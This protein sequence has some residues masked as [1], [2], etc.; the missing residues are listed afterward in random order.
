MSNIVWRARSRRAP[1]AGYSVIELMMT[2]GIFAVL[3]SMAVL[4]IGQ[5]QPSIKGDGALRV[6]LAQ[7]NAALEMAITNR[8]L[9]RVV[10]TANNAVQIV[11]EKVPGPTLEVKSTVPL[12]GGVQFSVFTDMDDTPMRFGN[13]TAVAFGTAVEMKFT[14]DGHFVN[15]SGADLNGSVFLALPK[16]KASARALTVM[17]STGQIRSW[18]WNGAKWQ[19][20]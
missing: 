13:S 16:Q 11:E 15:Q 2:M 14:P 7:L 19:L 10:F 17:G 6:V 5:A 1:A 12:E 8:R 4:Q 9:M 3:S 20:F 18:K